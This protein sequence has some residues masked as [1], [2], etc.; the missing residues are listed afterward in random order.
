MYAIR[1]DGEEYIDYLV[2]NSVKMLVNECNTLGET[3]MRHTLH[4]YGQDDGKGNKM[5]SLEALS[6]VIK[7]FHYQMTEVD[8]YELST[9]VFN[10]NLIIN[11]PE[12]F[13]EEIVFLDIAK[14]IK[15][16]G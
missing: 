12:H 8:S 3:L 11:A 6:L 13:R 2:P 14:I 5:I 9:W 10:N 4:Q 1:G 15:C 7:L 16:L